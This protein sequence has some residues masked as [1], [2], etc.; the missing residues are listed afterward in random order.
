MDPRRR[1]IEKW[2][3]AQALQSDRSKF[4]S[5]LQ[6]LL[7]VKLGK[8][9]TSKPQLPQLQNDDNNIPPQRVALIE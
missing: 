8:L 1:R 3:R 5:R 6:D 7:P 9:R 2:L 4:I